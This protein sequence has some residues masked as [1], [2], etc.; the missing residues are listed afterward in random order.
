MIKD[1]F[2]HCVNQRHIHAPARDGHTVDQHLAANPWTDQQAG[3]IL[4][5][6]V[7]VLGADAGAGNHQIAG[8]Q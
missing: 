8:T 1:H 6:K 3:S 4:P 7:Q 2:L 5:G